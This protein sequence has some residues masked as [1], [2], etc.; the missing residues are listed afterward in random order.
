MGTPQVAS[1]RKEDTFTHRVGCKE[2]HIATLIAFI[3][4]R[5]TTTTTTTTTAAAATTTT[6]DDDDDTATNTTLSVIIII[7]IIFK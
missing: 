3:S 7:I 1:A 6:A 5:F 4:N 2:L